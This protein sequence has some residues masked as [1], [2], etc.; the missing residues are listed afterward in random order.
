MRRSEFDVCFT[1]VGVFWASAGHVTPHTGDAFMFL[2]TTIGFLEDLN[3]FYE[4]CW[5]SWP[6]FSP[7]LVLYIFIDGVVLLCATVRV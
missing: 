3:A 1:R 2:A 4:K 6:V 7:M 5:P